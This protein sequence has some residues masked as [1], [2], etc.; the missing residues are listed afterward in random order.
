[1]HPRTRILVQVTIYH[2]LRMGQ[3]QSRLIKRLRYI[4]TCTIK[5][6]QM[7]LHGHW[8]IGVGPS[9]PIVVNATACET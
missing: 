7:G 3:D 6:A 9:R 8:G 4:V 2:S 5:R 1:M